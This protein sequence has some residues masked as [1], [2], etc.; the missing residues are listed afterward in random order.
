MFPKYNYLLRLSN[1][2]VFRCYSNTYNSNYYGRI[3]FSTSNSGYIESITDPSYC[4]QILVFSSLNIGNCGFTYSDFESHRIWLSAIVV[5]KITTY[6]SNYRSDGNISRLLKR[7]KVIVLET[8]NTRDIVYEIRSR[9]IKYAYIYSIKK[10]NAPFKKREIVNISIST[11]IPYCYFYNR[12]NN[13]KVCSKVLVLDFGLKNNM[14]ISL[15]LIGLFPL[16]ESTSSF[17]FSF[18]TIKPNGILLSSGPGNANTFTSLIS[19]VSKLISI[20]KIPILGICL[21]HQIISLCLNMCLLEMKYGHHGVNHP[22][23][24]LN[25]KKLLISTQNHNFCITNRYCNTNIFYSL[26]DKSIQGF[27]FKKDLIITIQGHPESSPGV[28]DL[29]F[30]FGNFKEMILLCQKKKYW[31]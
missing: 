14:F 15:G 5:N 20:S 30:V 10:I 4:N 28:K 27:L 7:Y 2:M 6:Y 8:D 13:Y 18:T 23:K 1:G 19:K 29:R 17:M 11:K 3:V 31:L 25:C 26:F 16:I 24:F 21:G 22:I 9:S 12:F